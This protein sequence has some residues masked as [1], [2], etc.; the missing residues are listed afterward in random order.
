MGAFEYS[1]LDKGG[2]ECKGVLEGDSPRQIRQ[3]LREQGMIPLAVDEV[4]HHENKPHTRKSVFKLRRGISASDLALLTRQLA[5]LVRSGIPLV[6][7]AQTIARQSEKPRLQSLM[8][9]VGSRIMEGHSLADGLGKF[10]HVF[11]ELYRATV[12]AGEQSGHLDGVLEKLADYTEARQHLSQRVQMALF[13]PALLTTMS[14]LVVSGLLA[15]VVPEVVKVFE[16]MNQQLP[17]LTR[18]LIAV[19]G[20]FRHWL[21]LVLIVLIVGAVTTVYTLRKPGPKYTYHRYMLRV[22]IIGRFVRRINTARF[23]RTLSILTASGVPVLESLRISAHVVSNLPMREAVERAAQKVREGAPLARSL[24]QSGYFPPMT[25]NLIASGEVSGKLE[26]MLERAA[27]NQERE[28][29]TSISLMM[30]MLEPILILVMGGVVLVIVL[31][32]LLPI[33]NMNDLVH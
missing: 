3:Q 7:A 30:S 11:G 5:T 31:A 25:V 4:A 32:I 9:G 10:P 18:M 8:M 27:S 13:Y 15:Y 14:I 16:D 23:A 19:S 1:A 33:F 17:L 22:P 26:E 6:E 21:W 24:E 29:E 20:F 28:Q 12:S 2:K